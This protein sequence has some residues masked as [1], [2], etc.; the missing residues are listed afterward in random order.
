VLTLI[1]FPM[2]GARR[3]RAGK[4]RDVLATNCHA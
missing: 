1:R 4:E 2:R 3:H